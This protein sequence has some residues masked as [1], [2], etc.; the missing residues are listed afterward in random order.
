M[1]ALL[2]SGCA[3]SASAGVSDA[4]RHGRVRD[5]LWAYDRGKPDPGALQRIAAVALE[6][7]AQAAD[8]RQR[9]QALQ[10]LENAKPLSRA[11]L[12]RLAVRAPNAFTRARALSLLA[13]FGDQDA[14]AA[15]LAK[16]DD[17]DAEVRGLAIEALDPEAEA[18]PLRALCDSPAASARLAAVHALARARP[19]AESTRML[20]RLA[21]LDP[22]LRVRAAALDALGGGGPEVAEAIESQLDELDLGVRLAAVNALVRVDYARASERLA[23]YLADDPTLLGIEAART[24]L[25][26]DAA[27]APEAARSQLVRALTARDNALR[28]AGAVALMSLHD[29]RLAGAARERAGH[30]PVRSVQ[31]NLA[32]A[33]G[34]AQP[35]AR[36][37]LAQL[38]TR[39]DLV[40]T[41]AAAELA[42]L[43]DGGAL[44]TLLQHA[45]LG[46][47]LVRRTAVRVLAQELGRIQDA[48]PALSDRDPGVRIAAA[49]AI[50]AA[51]G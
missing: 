38:A 22:A 44:R 14:R 15:L 32:L 27:R 12:M 13:R 45:R 21:R 25:A 2:L 4:L 42:R 11:V 20:A 46:D 39:R 34:A 51:P 7:A 1:V 18:E 23:R 8:A 33:L 48:R 31:L 28:A 50:L 3:A 37:W 19:V 10:A 49:G 35:E 30:E 43:G 47:P 5:A 40:A 41:Q 26:A 36:A 16:L 9:A 29:S 17:A 6:Q 24:L